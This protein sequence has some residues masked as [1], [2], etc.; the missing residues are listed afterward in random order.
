MKK[1]ATLA[2]VSLMSFAA[3]AGYVIIGNPAGVDAMSDA[4]VKQ[5]F[6]GKKTQLANGQPAKIIELNDGNAD[7]IAFHEA[8]TGRSEAQLQS[9]WSRLVF[10]GKAEAPTQVADYTAVIN[11]VA[12]DANAI[13]YVDESAVNGSVK[14]LIKY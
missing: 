14:V 2:L 6:L 8:T 7:R 13:G 5:L 1:I 9:A 3:N 4:E 11:A 10:T 12:A